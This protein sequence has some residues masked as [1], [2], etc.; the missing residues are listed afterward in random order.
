VE[1]L[2]VVFSTEKPAAGLLDLHAGA[3]EQQKKKKK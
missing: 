3:G 1:D 2:V